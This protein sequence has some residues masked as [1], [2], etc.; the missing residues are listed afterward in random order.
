MY[1]YMS[2]EKIYIYIFTYE[3]IKEKTTQNNKKQ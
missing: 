2:K 1:I 3:M